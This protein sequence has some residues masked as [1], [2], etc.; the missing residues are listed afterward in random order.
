MHALS[1]YVDIFQI[2]VRS[3]DVFT[4][5]GAGQ[6]VDAKR[7]AKRRG[8]DKMKSIIRVFKRYCGTEFRFFFPSKRSCPEFF[9][10]QNL[11]F[12][13]FGGSL[14]SRHIMDMDRNRRRPVVVTIEIPLQIRGMPPPLQLPSLSHCR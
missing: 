8:T 2:D 11:I 14:G 13:I 5:N 6:L 9:I 3:A 10:F 7:G 12:S 4:G 1:S